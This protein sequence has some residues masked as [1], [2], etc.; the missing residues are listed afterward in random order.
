MLPQI[1][2]IVA[3]Q[4]DVDLQICGGSHVDL[5]GAVPGMDAAIDRA[6]AMAGKLR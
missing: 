3:A 6:R 1:N 4:S 2:G 5:D